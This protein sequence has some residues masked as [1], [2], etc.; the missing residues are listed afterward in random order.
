MEFK[1]PREYAGKEW[2]RKVY[3]KPPYWGE[4]EER[5]RR[6]KVYRVAAVGGPE[7]NE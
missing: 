2:N 7:A 3:R 6:E 1:V 4:T 5:E